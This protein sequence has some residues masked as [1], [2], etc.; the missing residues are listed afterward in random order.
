MSTQE[1]LHEIKI[2]EQLVDWV[3]SSIV[4]PTIRFHFYCTEM[5]NQRNRIFFYRRY[6]CIFFSSL[7]LCRIVWANIRKQSIKRLNSEIYS[8]ISDLKLPGFIEA[9]KKRQFGYS[10]IRL[11]PKPNGV[12]PILNF[13]RKTILQDNYPKGRSSLPTTNKSLPDWMD[14]KEISRTTLNNS[15]NT[16]EPTK[17]VLRS[18]NAVLK[19][20]FCAI[21]YEKVSKQDTSSK[22]NR[23]EKR[24]Q[25]EPIVKQ[26]KYLEIVYFALM[27]FIFVLFHL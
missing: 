17:T 6:V 16:A 10:Y 3:F 20:A 9:M 25:E 13:K 22:E 21:Q 1:S 24:V 19:N 4:I 7:I 2:L 5:S 27:I 12:R 15:R 26:M 8:P 14:P 11:L 18:I 23:I